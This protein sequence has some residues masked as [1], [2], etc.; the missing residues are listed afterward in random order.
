MDIE[1]RLKQSQVQ[2][3][4]AIEVMNNLSRLEQP[5]GDLPEMAI[6]LDE[7]IKVY[8]EILEGKITIQNTFPEK[9]YK[10]RKVYRSQHHE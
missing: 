4:K 9:L 5:K 8:Q 1:E 10:L 7:R 3:Q 6:R 2:L